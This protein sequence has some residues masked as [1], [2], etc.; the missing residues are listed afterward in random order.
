MRTSWLSGVPSPPTEYKFKTLLGMKLVDNCAATIR[1]AA[2]RQLDLP[3]RGRPGRLC[4]PVI[5][6]HGCASSA[7]EADTYEWQN[8]GRRG[9]REQYESTDRA[10]VGQRSDADDDETAPRLAD[11]SGSLCRGVADGRGAAV[12]E[13]PQGHPRGQGGLGGVAP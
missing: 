11:P 1:S 2:R 5:N 7:D 13:R 10:G 3:L 9:G 6:G 8:T 4:Q 12:A